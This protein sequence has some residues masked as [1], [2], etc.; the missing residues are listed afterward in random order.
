M[1][2]VRSEPGV[3][4]TFGLRI[5]IEPVESEL[6][7]ARSATPSTRPDAGNTMAR[8][9]GRILL[10]EDGNDNRRLLTHVLERA[11]ATVTAV[12]NGAEALAALAESA[13][14]KRPFDLVVTDLQM[15]VMDGY[16]L[17]REVRGSGGGG[18]PIVALTAHAM[19][20][21]RERCF[22]AGCDDYAVKPI[23]PSHFLATC[24]HWL[25]TSRDMH[26]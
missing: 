3:G 19:A 18:V 23:D 6:G 13:E 4:S 5:P 10:V 14:A 17:I 21:D 20:E 24:A 12:T 1:H 9:H 16:T 26:D 25:R 2:L 11:G 7:G 22:A 8:L 15:P